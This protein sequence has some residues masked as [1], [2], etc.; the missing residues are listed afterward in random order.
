MHQLG[1]ANTLK[2]SRGNCDGYCYRR[3]P[4]IPLPLRVPIPYTDDN[5][6]IIYTK[7]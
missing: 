1:H 7:F 3:S 4:N 2:V 5:C 6:F